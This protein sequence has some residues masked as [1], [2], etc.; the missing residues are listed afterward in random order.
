M[1]RDPREAL[2]AWRHSVPYTQTDVAALFKVSKGAV[3]WWESGRCRVPARVRRLLK[4]EGWLISERAR[5]TPDEDAWL[6]AHVGTWPEAEVVT[7]LNVR[8]G[9]ERTRGAVERRVQHVHHISLAVVGLL[10]RDQIA[11][12]C[13]VGRQMV[14]AWAERGWL[15][16]PPW[17]RRG[18]RGQWAVPPAVLEAFIAQH[19]VQLHPA[20]MPP[21]P[22][23]QQAAAIW[24]RERWLSVSQVATHAGVCMRVARAWIA[25]GALPAT[26]QM[27]RG[28]FWWMIRARDLA[29]FLKQ[30]DAA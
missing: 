26:R 25:A 2:I 20:A 7:R 24:A 27:R 5:W 21:S 30:R 15:D 8:F 29:T 13:G 22:Y 18:T 12:L 1:T 23:Q 28:R 11:R 9:N 4:T 14:W 16:L 17:S 6:L 19:A 3:G 10:N